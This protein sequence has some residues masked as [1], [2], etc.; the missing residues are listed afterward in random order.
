M[1]RLALALFALFPIAAA[2]NE[3]LPSQLAFQVS[4]NRVDNQTLVLNFQMPEGYYLYKKR[5]ALV[6]SS[7]FDVT[8]LQVTGL[9]Q[10]SDPDLGVE[11]VLD[12]SSRVVLHGKVAADVPVQVRL[13]IQGCLKGQVCY[14]PEVRLVSEY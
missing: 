6:G 5:L 12:S 11:D 7:G 4:M 10:L 8:N 9:K 2:A 3:P 1:K 14:P 13:K